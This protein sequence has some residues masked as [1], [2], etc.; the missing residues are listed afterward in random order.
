[1]A[2]GNLL[3]KLV[4]SAITVLLSLLFSCANVLGFLVKKIIDVKQ[5]TIICYDLRRALMTLNEK[6]LT[7]QN[8]SVICPL[9]R[10]NITNYI[11]C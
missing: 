5:M 6:N 11:K 2:D 4:L 10:E 9:P 3:S 7:S 1:M 8:S